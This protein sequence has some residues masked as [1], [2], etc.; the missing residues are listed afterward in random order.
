MEIKQKKRLLVQFLMGSKFD[1]FAEFLFA[2]KFID[3]LK[4]AWNNKANRAITY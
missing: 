4:T 3:K 1:N 2:S